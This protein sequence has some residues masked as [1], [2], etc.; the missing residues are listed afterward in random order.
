MDLLAAELLKV[1][2]DDEPIVLERLR[3]IFVEVWNGGEMPQEWK[4]A[5]IKVLYKKG[6]RSNYNNFRGISLLR[7]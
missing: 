2:G 4:D 5:I 6:D 3:A 1:D 7:M